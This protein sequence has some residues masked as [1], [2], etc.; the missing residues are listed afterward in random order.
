MMNA[1]KLATYILRTA[2]FCFRILNRKANL[3]EISPSPAHGVWAS[4]P[5]VKQNQL[6]KKKKRK[7]DP[8]VT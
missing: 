2:F 3:K 7:E 8:H 5:G 4:R 6:I 1:E